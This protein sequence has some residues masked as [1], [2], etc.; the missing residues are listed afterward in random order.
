MRH[1][2]LSKV[3][4]ALKEID[5]RLERMGSGATPV[6]HP[7]HGRE[8]EIEKM[9]RSLSLSGGA[10]AYLDYHLPRL[11]RSLSLAPPGGKRA[12]ELGCY[13]HSSA[14]LERV[15]G[16]AEVRGAYYAAEPGMD[17]KVLALPDGPDFRM[18]IDLFDA[19]RHAFPYAAGHF[20]L[21]LC[22]E[23]VEH[24]L[25]DPMHLLFE[26]HRVLEEGGL[27]LVTTPNAASLHSV[28][29]ALHGWHSP[30]VHAAYPAPGSHDIPHVREYTAR[31]LRDAVQAAGFEIK[32]LFTERIAGFDEGAW[33]RDL[34]T[35]EGFDTG[36]RGEPTYC[37]A[38]RRSGL[39]RERYPRW[40]Y[41]T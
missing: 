19:E 15:L 12:L 24:L 30:Q 29:C 14:V 33:V 22:C 2:L 32:A 10:R 25:L 7:G 6:P 3:R 26:C 31:E 27:L 40:L 37:L 23:L 11:V 18:E 5:I 38:R 35:R 1:I 4:R 8:A 20:D 13:V 41:A 9:L 34:L 39:P 28:A 21:V 16:Y 36:L 17:H